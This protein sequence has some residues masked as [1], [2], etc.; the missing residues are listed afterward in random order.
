MECPAKVFDAFIHQVVRNVVNVD[1]QKWEPYEKW[2]VINRYLEKG[3]LH[4]T[5]GPD[6]QLLGVADMEEE[7]DEPASEAVGA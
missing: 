2:R 5:S 3:L 1:S 6:G 7:V 4:L